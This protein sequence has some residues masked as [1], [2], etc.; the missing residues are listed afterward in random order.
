VSAIIEETLPFNDTN[1]DHI[2]GN[3]DPRRCIFFGPTAAPSTILTRPL[4]ALAAAGR[5]ARLLGAVLALVMRKEVVFPVFGRTIRRQSG[6]GRVSF[7]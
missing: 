4:P 3:S 1:W 6:R 7:E 2:S 5:H